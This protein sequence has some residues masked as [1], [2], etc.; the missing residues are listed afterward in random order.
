MNWLR[1][2]IRRGWEQA[3][4]EATFPLHVSI[5]DT[6][7]VGNKSRVLTHNMVFDTKEQLV[8]FVGGSNG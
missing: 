4:Q 6:V 2:F 5:G 1:W 7:R 3:E 8:N